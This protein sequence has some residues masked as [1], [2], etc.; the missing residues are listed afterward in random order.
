MPS[1]GLPVPSR[2]SPLPAREPSVL[3]RGSPVPSRGPPVP[4]RGHLC[5]P[6][7]LHCHPEGRGPPLPAGGGILAQDWGPPCPGHLPWKELGTGHV[8]PK[9][10][11]MATPKERHNSTTESDQSSK[12]T[13]QGSEKK[14]LSSHPFRPVSGQYANSGINITYLSFEGDHDRL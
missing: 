12:L 14:F 5:R 2:G 13:M 10:S 3:S 4:T 6:E 7:G 11:S 1:R 9:R 8:P